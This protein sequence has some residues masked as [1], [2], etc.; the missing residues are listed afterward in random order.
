MLIWSHIFSRLA[1]TDS[2]WGRIPGLY[3]KYF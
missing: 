3:K 2:I 1:H